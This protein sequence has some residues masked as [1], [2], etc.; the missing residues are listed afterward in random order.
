MSSEDLEIRITY[1]EDQMN[2]MNIVL[3]GYQNRLDDLE[4]SLTSV[5]KRLRLLEEDADSDASGSGMH[6]PSDQAPD[7]ANR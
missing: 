5:R 6:R 3:S 7:G 1:L 4:A 2:R